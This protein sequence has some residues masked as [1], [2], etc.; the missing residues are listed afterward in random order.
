MINSN[1]FNCFIPI[2]FEKAK[3]DKKEGKYDNMVFVSMASDNSEDADEEVLEPSGFDLTSFLKSG[4]INL[5]HYT[6]RKG[7]AYYWIGEPIDAKVKNNKLFI[8]GK[9]WKEHP[10]ARNFWDV[11]NIMEKSGSTRKA[12]MSIEGTAIQ[13]D[14]HNPKRVIKARIDNAAVTLSPKNFNSILDI[15]K[16]NYDDLYIEP[17]VELIKGEN[18]FE[19][20]NKDGDLV[21]IDKDFKTTIN[22]AMSAGGLTGTDLTGQETSGAALK[23]ESLDP[24]VKVLQPDFIE[25]VKTI[26][27]KKKKLNKKVLEEIKKS[28][29]NY[30]K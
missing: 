6:T 30:F 8:K 18:L 7:D 1:K 26:S 29:E 22:K 13:R 3:D 10:L 25:A 11:I 15:V 4:K 14:P 17:D 21:K 2:E 9:L 27:K 28:I 16:G 24:K 20:T 19:Y 5:E 12:G 23:K